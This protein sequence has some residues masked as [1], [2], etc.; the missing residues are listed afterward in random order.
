MGFDI[1]VSRYDVGKCPIPGVSQ[2]KDPVRLVDANSI[3]RSIDMNGSAYDGSQNY[4]LHGINK[5]CG[6]S[7]S[8]ESMEFIYCELGNAVNHELCRR[9]VSEM[10]CNLN[11]LQRAVLKM[12]DVSV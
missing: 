6:M 5:V 10:D 7:F 9:F 1:T 4:H 11:K 3:L 2:P 8:R 12:R